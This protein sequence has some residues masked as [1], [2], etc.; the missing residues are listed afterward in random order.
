MSGQKPQKFPMCPDCG[1]EVRL[2]ARSGRTREVLRG[3]HVPVPADFKIPTCLKCGEES[4]NIELAEKLDSVLHQTLIDD[5]RADVG[6]ICAAHGANQQQVEDA[7]GV[8]RT[9]L[10]HVLAGRNPPSATFVKF[11]RS[12]ANVPGA[13]EYALGG[14]Q[15]PAR[16]LVADPSALNEV[17][18]KLL[19]Q[20]QSAS[21]AKFHYAEPSG[22]RAPHGPMGHSVRRSPYQG[23]DFNSESGR[24][25]VAGS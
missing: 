10:S 6:R 21:F 3:V 24:R 22:F 12:F 4:F 11:L 19:G 5:L 18:L 14:S 7:L 8:T 20:I 17:F 9:Y 23:R 16:P 15:S 2:A 25:T 13:Y 1:G